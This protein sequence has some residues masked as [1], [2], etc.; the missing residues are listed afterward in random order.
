MSAIAT[1]KTVDEKEASFTELLDAMFEDIERMRGDGTPAPIRQ[2]HERAAGRLHIARVGL[3]DPEA[4]ARLEGAAREALPDDDSGRALLQK[5]ESITKAEP[6]VSSAE[7]FRRA[8][9]DPTISA[10][11]YA[12]SGTEPPAPAR[13]AKSEGDRQ[14]A[15][16][17]AVAAHLEKSGLSPTAAYAQALRESPAYAQAA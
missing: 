13:L 10:A 17:Q 2:R 11:Y 1:A 16:V 4:A 7:A 12:Q 14:A 6:G 3:R 5:C 15:D 8:L 9:A